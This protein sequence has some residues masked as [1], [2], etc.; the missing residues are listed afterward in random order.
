MVD[1]EDLVAR[2]LRQVVAPLVAADGGELYVQRAADGGVRVHL[3]GACAGCPG[4]RYTA[5]EI[6]EPA[7]RAAGCVGE[8]EI[9]AGWTIPE[10]A[11]RVT[12]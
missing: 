3:A 2:T 6:V 9:S 4:F 1:A 8:L 5:H 12:P 11:E 7:V 10:G